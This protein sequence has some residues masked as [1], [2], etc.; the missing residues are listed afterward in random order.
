MILVM[1]PRRIVRSLGVYFDPLCAQKF[2]Y[3]AAVLSILASEL[4][5]TQ[6][7][8]RHP[9]FAILMVILLLAGNSLFGFWNRLGKQVSEFREVFR[10]QNAPLASA[11]KKIR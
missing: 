4:L 11:V 6:A 7:K 9:N 5:S 8:H 1:T 2:I 3:V 10:Q